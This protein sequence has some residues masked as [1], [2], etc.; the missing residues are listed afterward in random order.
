MSATPRQHVR[1]SCLRTLLV[2]LVGTAAA[3]ATAGPALGI[4][5]GPALGAT[6]GP[7]LGATAVPALGAAP[8]VLPL[9][10][11]C[12]L[13]VTIPVGVQ[14]GIAVAALPGG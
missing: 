5:A 4:T 12:G 3:G 7:A 6:A 1:R 11:G 8:A 10:T 2:A 13:L 9:V 14:A